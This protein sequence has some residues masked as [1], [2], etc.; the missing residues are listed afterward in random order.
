MQHTGLIKNFT[1][2]G[3]IEKRRL[4][5]FGVSEGHVVR[6][7]IGVPLLG[8]TAIRGAKAAGERVDVCLSELREVEFGG[9]VAFGDP[10]TSDA[11]GRA[12]KAEPAP[13]AKVHCIGRA[14]SA[15][16]V[17]VIGHTTVQ[18]FYLHG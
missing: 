13:G 10:L 14:M 17:G 12:V 16:G 3:P 2:D 6:A 7:G 15:G 9:P 4:V 8:T 1:A 11:T 5:T 18:P